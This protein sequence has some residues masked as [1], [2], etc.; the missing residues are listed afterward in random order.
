MC[1][2]LKPSEAW[3][4]LR[5]TTYS[6]PMPEGEPDNKLMADYVGKT[7]VLDKNPLGWSMLSFVAGNQLEI[8]DTVGR[9]G[10]VELGYQTWQT[11]LVDLYPLNA[12]YRVINQFSTIAPPFRVGASYAW[13][14]DELLTKI[15]FVDWMG[16][17]SLRFRFESDAVRIES[18][19]NYQNKPVSF[20]AKVLVP[21]EA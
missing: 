6:L 8:T 1:F 11:T 9:K 14:D 7:L 3:G 13:Q 4:K 19:E 5:E 2:F 17:V 12:R 15:H 21:P 16:A 20:S 10:L 18:V